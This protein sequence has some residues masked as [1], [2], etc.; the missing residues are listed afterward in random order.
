MKRATFQVK[1]YAVRAFVALGAAL[2]FAACT[3]I[4]NHAPESVYGPPPEVDS[5]IEA[6]KLVY[7]PPPVRNRAVKPDTT[8]TPSLPSSD[9]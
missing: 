7:G 4:K 3:Q 8:L 6:R 1:K 5:I 9:K 2:G